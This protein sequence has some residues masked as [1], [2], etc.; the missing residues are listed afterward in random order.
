MNPVSLTTY[1]LRYAKPSMTNEDNLI[2][3]DTWNLENQGNHNASYVFFY[4]IN[5]K[6]KLKNNSS[7]RIPEQ[8]CQL[9]EAV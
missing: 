2:S 7:N 5:T 3:L 4:H 8:V 1:L 9:R 6:H